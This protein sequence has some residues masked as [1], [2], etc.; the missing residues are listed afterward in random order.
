MRLYALVEE[1]DP[2]A[3]YVYLCEHDAQ[4][5][6]EDC[7]KDEPR[8][9]GLPRVEEL[10]LDPMMQSEIEGLL[11]LLSPLCLRRS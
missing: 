2:E 6:L 1:G 8:W 10:E 11:V 7:L 5:A 4:R 9:R 3:I